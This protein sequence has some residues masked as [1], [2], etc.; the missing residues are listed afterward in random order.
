[1]EDEQKLS[2]LVYK[3]NSTNRSVAR[4]AQRILKKDW[5]QGVEL[6]DELVKQ[7]GINKRGLC[8]KCKKRAC[9]GPIKGSAIS[10]CNH[11]DPGWISKT[12]RTRCTS[13]KCNKKARWGTKK[14]TKCTRHKVEGMKRIISCV[15]PG[16]NITPYYGTKWEPNT[17]CSYHSK[18]HHYQTIRKICEFGECQN[19]A[20]MGYLKGRKERCEEHA[21]SDM[22]SISLVQCSY[23]RCTKLADECEDHHNIQHVVVA[24]FEGIK[25]IA[26]KFGLECNS[27]RVLWADWRGGKLLVIR[28]N[29]DTFRL[30]TDR[31]N[32]YEMSSLFIPTLVVNLYPGG[33]AIPYLKRVKEITKTTF[34]SVARDGI[35]NIPVNW[36]SLSIQ[37][38]N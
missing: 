33:S 12:N 24:K 3:L 17:H 31:V 6:S 38:T 22:V 18:S 25:S 26:V 14:A 28:H 13:W 23:P 35:K 16:C 15:V 27:D 9:Y 19:F 20:D 30:P 10:C 37:T 29:L 11:A 36:E 34:L 4:F 5:T 32:Q 21:L 8:H 7:L 2:N 1:M